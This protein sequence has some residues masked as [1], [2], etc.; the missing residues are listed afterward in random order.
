MNDVS[1]TRKV[2]SR[3]LTPGHRLSLVC[4]VYLILSAIFGSMNLD[5][6]EIGFLREP[7]EMI[8]GDYTRRY[9]AEHDLGGAASTIGR[10]YY[11][12][13]KYRPLFAPI[14]DEEDR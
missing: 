14:I 1:W 13:W 10:S 7:Y 12:Y 5:V 3:S 9:L 2:A 11:F 4:A 6:D 8:G